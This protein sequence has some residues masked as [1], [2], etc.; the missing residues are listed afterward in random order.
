M[1]KNTNYS[2]GKLPSEADSGSPVPSLSRSPLPIPAPPLRSALALAQPRRR[3]PSAL[4][5]APRLLRRGQPA[6]PALPPWAPRSAEAAA[7]AR[8]AP[9]GSE[10]SPR[11]RPPALRRRAAP[12]P[13]GHGRTSRGAVPGPSR[14]GFVPARGFPAGGGREG[15]KQ[16]GSSLARRC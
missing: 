3:D 14:R 2:G 6:E 1:L 16:G 11:P 13:A 8:P 9:S 12:Q 15:A 10:R 5:T 4:P 7:P